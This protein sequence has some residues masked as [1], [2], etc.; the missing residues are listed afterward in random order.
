MRTTVALLVASVALYAM[1]SLLMRE[2]TQLWHLVAVGSV[3]GLLTG[4]VRC[5]RRGALIGVAAGCVLGLVAPFLY[6]PFWLVFT[7]PPHPE[8]DL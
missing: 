5:R 2:D 3:A 4:G 7:L 6:I 8:Y 1:V